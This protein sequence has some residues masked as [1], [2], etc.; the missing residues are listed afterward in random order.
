MPDTQNPLA[1]LIP[2]AEFA[3]LLGLKCLRTL[4]KWRQQRKGPEPIKVGRKVFYKRETVIRWLD[5]RE[6]WEG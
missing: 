1:D 2:E 3:A 6:G 4:Q 5:R